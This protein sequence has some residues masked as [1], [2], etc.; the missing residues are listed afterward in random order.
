[1]LSCS[2]A[3]TCSP[4]GAGQRVECGGG[5]RS[6][7]DLTG[8]E[9]SPPATSPVCVCVTCA[10]LGPAVSRVGLRPGTS[11]GVPSVSRSIFEREV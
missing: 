8:D 11:S 2:C 6:T 5:H 1:V 10:T 3:S 4:V 7:G 9:I